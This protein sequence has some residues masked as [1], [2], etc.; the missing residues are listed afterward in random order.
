MERI[1]QLLKQYRYG[2]LVL[3]VGMGLMLIP[4]EAGA[5]TPEEFV[6]ETVPSGLSEKLEKI[7]CQIDGAGEVRVLLSESTGERILYQ[8]DTNQGGDSLRQETVIIT[9]SDRSEDGL[10]TQ[11]IPARYLGAV[12]V[13]Q[14]GDRAAVRLAIVEAVGSITGLTSDKITVLKMK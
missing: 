10:V 14:G 6:A 7:L 5:S 4:S 9:D 3:L 13:C 2:V 12:V 8:V 11:I 1:M